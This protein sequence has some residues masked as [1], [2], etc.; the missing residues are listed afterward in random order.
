MLLFAICLCGAGAILSVVARFPALVA[1]ILLTILAAVAGA[2][3]SFLNVEASA[4]LPLTIVVA[5]IALQVGYGLGVVTRGGV[6]SF[7]EARRGV[8]TDRAARSTSPSQTSR[9]RAD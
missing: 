2:A 7:F 8:G 9:A 6:S 4:S 1:I 5:V 3:L